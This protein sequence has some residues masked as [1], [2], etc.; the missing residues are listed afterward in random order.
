MSLYIYYV[1]D[2]ALNALHA[3]HLEFLSPYEVGTLI[4]PHF[5]GEVVKLTMERLYNLSK[6][7]KA[8]NGQNQG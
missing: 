2:A 7:H 1:P 5:T 6:L 3:I 4:T 8:R